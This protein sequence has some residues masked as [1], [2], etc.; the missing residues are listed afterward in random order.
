[1]SVSSQAVV[2]GEYG[3]TVSQSIA[4]SFSKSLDILRLEDGI[5]DG[6]VRM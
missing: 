1:M 6:L 5:R 2:T 3:F 4:A